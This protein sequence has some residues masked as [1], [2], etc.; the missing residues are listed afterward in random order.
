MPFCL[1][2]LSLASLPGTEVELVVREADPYIFP[3]PEGL[4][5]WVGT[6]RVEAQV[7]GARRAAREGVLIL[8]P[9]SK[10]AF[11]L[12]E[13]LKGHLSPDLA[14]EVRRLR[15]QYEEASKKLI[16]VYQNL[17]EDVFFTIMAKF[18]ETEQAAHYAMMDE[19]NLARYLELMGPE[20]ARELTMTL[21]RQRAFTRVI[22]LAP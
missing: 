17:P 12:N 18:S 19:E 20:K 5:G 7:E 13:R 2:L 9:A 15:T 21:A 14:D 1:F 3:V 22:Q 4:R 10:Q 8:A 16:A 11:P 6:A